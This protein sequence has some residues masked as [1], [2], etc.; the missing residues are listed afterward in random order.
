MS[1]FSDNIRQL[2]V[3]KRYSGKL[4]QNLLTI[5]GMSQYEDGK[6]MIF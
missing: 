1:L 5:E 6:H 2:R 4:A 3:K